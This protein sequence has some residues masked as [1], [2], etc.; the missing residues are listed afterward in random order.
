MN[1][2][3][4][5]HQAVSGEGMSAVKCARAGAGWR[6]GRHREMAAVPVDDSVPVPVPF[7]PPFPAVLAPFSF[8]VVPA[9]PV[10]VTVAQ[11]CPVFRIT[12]AAD[13]LVAIPAEQRR[14]PPAF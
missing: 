12:E 5:F 1:C 6:K 4:Y 13:L 14:K 9:S 8:G 3:H 10:M 11:V 2:K 7:P